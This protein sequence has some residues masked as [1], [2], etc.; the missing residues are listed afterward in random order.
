MQGNKCTRNYV[1]M[2]RAYIA[3]I[4]CDIQSVVIAASFADRVIM[5]EDVVAAVMVVALA[6]VSIAVVVVVLVKAVVWNGVV[7]DVLADGN[8]NVWA[9]VTTA[10]EFAMPTPLNEPNR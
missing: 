4:P 7:I 2:R 5:A 8:V 9:A 6:V 1:E 10:L 3:S